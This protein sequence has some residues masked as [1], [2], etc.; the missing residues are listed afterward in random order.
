VRSDDARLLVSAI[1]VQRRT[2]GNLV[3]VLKQLSRTLRERKRLRDDVRVLTTQPRYSGYIAAVVPPAM[4]AALY[5]INRNSFDVL[6]TDPIGRIA[7]IGSGVL[8]V[9][10]LFLNSRLSRV[11]M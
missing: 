10:G 5:F 11:E 8:V 6:I 2:G 3:D 4:A 1:A 7:F 9:L